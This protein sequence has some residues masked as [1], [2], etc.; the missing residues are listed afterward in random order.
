[1][2]GRRRAPRPRSGRARGRVR[3]GRRGDGGGP[4]GGRRAR[5]ARGTPRGSDARRDPPGDEGGPRTDRGRVRRLPRAG[6]GSRDVP[7]RDQRQRAAEGLAEGQGR[8][9]VGAVDA[10]PPRVLQRLRRRRDVARLVSPPL[11]VAR[12][13]DRA[14]DG[15]GGTLSARGG[16]R[17]ARPQSRPRARPTRSPRSAGGRCRDCPRSTMRRW[18]CCAAAASCRWR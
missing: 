1:M 13:A 4:C 5:T 7:H 8:D 14:L 16:S 2:G 6:P 18:R 3:R 11:H 15:A 9:D 17:R 12:R 10:R